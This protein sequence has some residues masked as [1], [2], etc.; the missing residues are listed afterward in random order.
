[1][2]A[3]GLDLSSSSST[4]ASTAVPPAASSSSYLLPDDL[5]AYAATG[6]G[7]SLPSQEQMQQPSVSA[8]TV[9]A[10]FFGDIASMGA[11]TA[12]VPVTLQQQ[13]Q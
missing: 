5:G 12:S 10:G 7:A 11:L 1:M 8:A 9:P 6:E 3:A 13:L 2:F 4:S